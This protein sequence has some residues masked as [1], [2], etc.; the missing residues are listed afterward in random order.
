MAIVREETPEVRPAPL[1]LSSRELQVLERAAQGLTNAQI[2]AS[3][4]ITVHAT[5]FHLGS[6]Y[7][8]LGVANRTEAAITFLMLNQQQR[9]AS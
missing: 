6:I 8:K 1:K 4:T 9:T 5:K 2:A 3:L 7:R